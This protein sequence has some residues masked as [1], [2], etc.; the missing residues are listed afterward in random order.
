MKK[1]FL[2]VGFDFDGVILYNPIRI[3]RPIIAFIKS[4]FFNHKKPL[5]FYYPKTKIEKLCWRIFHLS[6]LF[7]SAGLKEIKKLVK[8]KKIKAYLITGRYSF[9]KKDLQ[10]W[11]RSLKL[12]DFF[13][14]IYYNQKDEQPHFFKEK[15]IKKLN[16]DIYI[17]DN[18]DIVNYLKNQMKNRK[19]RNGKK[20]KIFWIYNLFDR[21]IRYKN[22][23]SSLS[24]I[25]R[26][27][28]KRI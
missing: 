3:F 5:T 24:L 28:K 25:I 1:K 26:E 12:R 17:E 8:E 22:K 6:S 20:I 2:K 10:K 16:L 13:S 4:I 9:L 14:G 27:I 7:P 18:W 21:K 15:I 19:N 23:Y 11:I